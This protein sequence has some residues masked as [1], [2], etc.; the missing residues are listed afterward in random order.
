V[1]C[2]LLL[3][4]L[5]GCYEGDSPW[6][7]VAHDAC[8][9]GNLRAS[10]PAC[11]AALVPIAI[12]GDSSDWKD[13]PVVPVAPACVASSCAGLVPESLQFA[14][15]TDAFG[16]RALAFRVR[17]AGGERPAPL[18][19]DVRY[20]FEL[21]ETPEY[22]T[23]V[24]DQIIVGAS[25]FRYLRNGESFDL[26][27]GIAPP[28]FVELTAD[29][30]E[31]TVVQA[32]LP[33]PFGARVAAYAARAEPGLLRDLVESTPQARACWID[34]LPLTGFGGDPCRSDAP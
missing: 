9:P 6:A 27:P 1:R 10:G 22:P 25:D 4:V 13:V 31:G 33:F 12:D 18:P 34:S 19:V 14:R 17:L 32:G 30:L 11:A 8:A 20:V 26:P 5:A 29:G 24:I 3:A 28:F 15:T 23:G 2:L 21:T 7:G 16:R